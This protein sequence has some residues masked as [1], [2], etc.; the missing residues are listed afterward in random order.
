M[1]DAQ[2]RHF[3]LDM[4]DLDHSVVSDLPEDTQ[5][6]V[7]GT[8]RGKCALVNGWGWNS[9][10]KAVDTRGKSCITLCDVGRP[11][12]DCMYVW[13]YSPGRVQYELYFAPYGGEPSIGPLL[14][15]HTLSEILEYSTT[16]GFQELSMLLESSCG[17]RQ[18]V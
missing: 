18:A 11:S 15:A 12:H 6:F 10:S 4:M 13:V 9:I 1:L 2:I 3:D 7:Q 5:K 17:T 16:H 14:V 8:L